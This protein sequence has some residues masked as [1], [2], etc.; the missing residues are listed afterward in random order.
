MKI[1]RESKEEPKEQA[2]RINDIKQFLIKNCYDPEI[3]KAF[4]ESLGRIKTPFFTKAVEF[5]LDQENGFE[6]RL[7]FINFITLPTHLLEASFTEAGEKLADVEP[8]VA[9]S[10]GGGGGGF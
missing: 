3:A 5:R 7:D 10:G 6:M 9:S 2:A 4:A 8:Q 1:A